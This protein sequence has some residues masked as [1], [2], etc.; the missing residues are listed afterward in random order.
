VKSISKTY[1]KLV[2]PSIY[3]KETK[4]KELITTLVI[5]NTDPLLLNKTNNNSKSQI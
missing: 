2:F 4:N 5:P 3:V 1:P